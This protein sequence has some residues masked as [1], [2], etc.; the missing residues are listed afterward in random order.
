M[1]RENVSCFMIEAMKSHDV[2][3]PRIMTYFI[4]QA[5]GKGFTLASDGICDGI[6]STRNFT[7]KI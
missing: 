4:K 1:L 7:S 5:K 3:L 6:S 2:A